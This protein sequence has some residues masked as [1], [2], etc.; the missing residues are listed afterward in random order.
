M[1]LADLLYLLSAPA[2]FLAGG[3]TENCATWAFRQRI[4]KG[5]KVLVRRSHFADR[6]L[7]EYHRKGMRY[8]IAKQVPH[9]AWADDDGWIWQYTVKPEWEARWKHR[10]LL[11]AWAALWFYDGQVVQGDAEL[12]ERINMREK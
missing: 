4:M 8:W 5:G 2:L 11:L 6:L 10:S 1:R 9:F 7:P 12:G 3:I